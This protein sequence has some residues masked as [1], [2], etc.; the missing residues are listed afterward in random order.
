M[1][2]NASEATNRSTDRRVVRTRAAL[3]DALKSLML[4]KRYE[5]ITIKEICRSADVARSTFYAHYLGK[6][7]LRRDGLERLRVQLLRDTCAHAN[8]SFAFSLAVFQ[9][10]QGH[11]HLYRALSGS[12]GG[13]AILL[14]KIRQIVSELV[15]SELV[16]A[17]TTSSVAPRELVVQYTV[18]AFM[19]VLVWWLNEGAKLP[20][21]K[22]DALF[23]E[24]TTRGL[25][26]GDV[27]MRP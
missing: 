1:S 16:E 8:R 10:A 20:A 11:L 14:D 23:R 4:R 12:R 6:S 7:D 21:E 3:H 9:Q 18:G 24:L 2:G 13:R 15:R 27:Q 19:S 17:G 25:I 5:T 26:R 22:V